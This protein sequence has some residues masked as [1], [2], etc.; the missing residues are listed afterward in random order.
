MVRDKRW[1]LIS[2]RIAE[3]YIAHIAHDN[4]ETPDDI[5]ALA[6]DPD[7]LLSEALLENKL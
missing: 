4:L 1:N 3:G 7:N 2:P 5:E 6:L